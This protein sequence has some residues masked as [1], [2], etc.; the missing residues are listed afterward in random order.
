MKPDPVKV[1]AIAQM[2]TQHEKSAVYYLLR[3]INFLGSH[4]PNLALITALL[5]DLV[6]AD[7]HFHWSFEAWNTIKSILA[8]EPIPVL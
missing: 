7:V 2:P 3:M 6:K 8:T 1:Q 5:R 4:I